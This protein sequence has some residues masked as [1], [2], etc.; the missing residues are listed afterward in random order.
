MSNLSN[1]HLIEPL[2]YLSFVYILKLS[3]LILT[4][5]AEFK[6]RHLAFKTFTC[7]R[8][9]TER[10]ESINAGV[11]KLVGLKHD[12]IVEETSSLLDSAKGTKK[13]K[14]AKNYMEMERLVKEFLLH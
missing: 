13:C 7:L 6:R 14:I 10:E 11:A 9:D 3:Y 2:D 4:I 12:K 1:V 8:N 5:L